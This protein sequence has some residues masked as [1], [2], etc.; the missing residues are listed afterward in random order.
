MLLT[1]QTLSNPGISSSSLYQLLTLT[2]RT[3]KKKKKN[4]CAFIR[5]S[6][7]IFVCNKHQPVTERTV[8]GPWACRPRLRLDPLV[9]IPL[10]NPIELFTKRIYFHAGRL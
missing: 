9:L 6:D 8:G 2:G 4:L 3:V 7:V 1:L 5:T 10:N